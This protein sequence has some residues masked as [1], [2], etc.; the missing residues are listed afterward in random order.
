MPN[1][2]FDSHCAQPLGILT[3]CQGDASWA[4]LL[5]VNAVEWRMLQGSLFRQGT[6]H[7]LCDPKRIHLDETRVTLR[8]GCVLRVDAVEWGILLGVLYRQGTFSCMSHYD[9]SIAVVLVE[10]LRTTLPVMWVPPRCQN[11]IRLPTVL[12]VQTYSV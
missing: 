5:R 12:Q 8:G 9:G 3:H 4:C 10:C 6:L 11:G 7:C 2:V 1:T